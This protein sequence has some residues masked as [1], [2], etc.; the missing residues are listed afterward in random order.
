[1]ELLHKMNI[2][3]Q[4]AYAVEIPST[5]EQMPGVIDSVIEVLEK[6]GA[7][8]GTQEPK[9]RICMQEAIVNAIRHG[10]K[11]QL[12]K[13]VRVEVCP[14]N[15][16]CAIKIYDEGEGFCPDSVESPDATSAGG[17]GIVLMRHFMD[18]VNFDAATKCLELRL[19]LPQKAQGE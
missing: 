11:G 3:L 9:I 12:E 7:I 18:A 5:C 16:G 8:N 19:A 15:E 2:K 13:T 10:N 14:D 6:L 17:R 1:M 4:P